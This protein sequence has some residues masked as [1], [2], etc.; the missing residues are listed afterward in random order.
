MYKQSGPARLAT[1]SISLEYN[2]I[3]S[4]AV[5]CKELIS[6]DQRGLIYLYQP[7]NIVK[8]SREFI[9][10]WSSY[11]FSR[12]TK[13]LELSNSIGPQVLF[14]YNNPVTPSRWAPDETVHSGAAVK[15]KWTGSSGRSEPKLNSTPTPKYKPNLNHKTASRK[16]LSYVLFGGGRIVGYNS[17]VAPGE[18]NIAFSGTT[19]ANLL[20][21]YIRLTQ[22]TGPQ[23]MRKYDAGGFPSSSQT[24]GTRRLRLQNLPGEL[25][26]EPA[27]RVELLAGAAGYKA[28]RPS[29]YAV[30]GVRTSGK[31]LL[32]D[33]D[34]DPDLREV[35]LERRADGWPL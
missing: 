28:G 27:G 34:S 30:R 25:F 18:L 13:W 31:T 19:G 6:P 35:G 29:S 33:L 10:G 14:L 22:R 11:G 23:K 2:S 16:M 7:L 21:F 17:K 5:G 15:S 26:L 12:W 20:V 8:K 3:L 32:G 9:R 24:D 4:S 1:D